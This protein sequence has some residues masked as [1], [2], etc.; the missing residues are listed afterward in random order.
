RREAGAVTA[1]PV[2]TRRARAPQLSASRGYFL[3]ALAIVGAGI[4]LRDFL[5]W[6]F[7]LPDAWVVPVADWISALFDWLGN[8]ADLGLFTVR[9]L[10][11]GFAWL[12]AWPLGWADA[13]LY[14]GFPALGLPQLPWI[15]LVLLV[16]ILGHA[17]AGW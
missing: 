13:V 6:T 4:L 14:S 1:V 12:L 16:T 3:L 5:P 17:I 8:S 11:R 9:D 10:T 2:V 15:T 7:R